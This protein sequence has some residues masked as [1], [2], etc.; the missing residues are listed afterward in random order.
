MPINEQELNEKL[1]G[2]SETIGNAYG[3]LMIRQMLNTILLDPEGNK[4][5]QLEC[6]KIINQFHKLCQLA[7]SKEIKNN[8]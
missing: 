8:G 2:I 6:Y 7:L 4:H 3:F 1:L 5:Q